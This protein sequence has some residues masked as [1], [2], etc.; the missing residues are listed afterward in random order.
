MQNNVCSHIFWYGDMLLHVEHKTLNFWHTKYME[1]CETMTSST[2]SFAYSYWLFKKCFDENYEN[3]TNF[4]FSL[5]FV[6]FT[7]NVHCS[8]RI[9]LFFW[10]KLKPHVHDKPLYGTL[11]SSL[12]WSPWLIP[13]NV[14]L[15]AQNAGSVD[16]QTHPGPSTEF[17]VPSPDP[18]WP[19]E[20]HY[21]RARIRAVHATGLLHTEIV[22]HTSQSPHT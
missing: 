13:H 14:L 7:L 6:W 16:K 4:I 8:V 5:Y 18:I 2:H 11:T 15:N 20:L 17:S 3:L 1:I 22:W 12:C 10:I 9:F 19:S 21:A